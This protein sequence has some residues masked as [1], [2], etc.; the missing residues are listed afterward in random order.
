MLEYLIPEV[1]PMVLIPKT[2]LTTF[3]VRM[4]SELYKVHILEEDGY[5]NSN[6]ESKKSRACSYPLEDQNQ[7]T[8]DN[9]EVELCDSTVN[10][11]SLDKLV[12]ELHTAFC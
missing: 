4:M 10:Q 7:Q 9:V 1:V 6:K 12:A 2:L 11:K 3:F 5:M 8:I